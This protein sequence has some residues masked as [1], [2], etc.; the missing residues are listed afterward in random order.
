MENRKCNIKSCN[1]NHY[2]LLLCSFHFKC[3]IVDNNIK[4]KLSRLQRI[5]EK[6]ANTKDII[7]YRIHVLFYLTTGINVSYVE[8][9][10]LETLYLHFKN[11]IYTEE[12]LNFSINQFF[13][14]FEYEKNRELNLIKNHFLKTEKNLTPIKKFTFNKEAKKET[15]YFIINTIVYL[16][17]YY[18]T[19]DQLHDNQLYFDNFSVLLVL[20]IAI[21]HSGII[22]SNSAK[23]LINQSINKQLF[24]EKNENE[25]FLKDVNKYLAHKKLMEKWR[26]TS[27]ITIILVNL[28]FCFNLII[29]NNFNITIDIILNLYLYLSSLL[30]SIKVWN[31]LWRNSYTLGIIKKLKSFKSFKF[32]LYDLDKNLGIGVIKSFVKSVL[33]YNM[34]VIFTF[35]IFI[36][37]GNLKS[38]E[39]FIVILG[40][41]LIFLAIYIYS[42][43]EI[44]SLIKT[45]KYQFQ[46]LQK[47]ELNNLSKSNSVSRITKYEFIEK[48]KLD[49]FL[50]NNT[51]L[52]TTLYIIPFIISHFISEFKN[53]INSSFLEFIKYINS[54]INYLQ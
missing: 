35:F 50:K 21:I 5:V 19:K 6:K 26:I 36:E 18:Y 24:N 14:N 34:V 47:N 16:C 29:N 22:F 49:F 51:V 27:I 3:Y 13:S 12:K 4:N 40:I 39:N 48:L 46:K 2:D 15:I 54:K 9:F 45:L 23:D 43:I 42:S 31:L 20:S 53:E 30:L 28:K 38:H 33:I 25:T 11:K 32:E 17:T 41:L 1:N 8:R 44:F 37:Q 52:K 10:P 7:I